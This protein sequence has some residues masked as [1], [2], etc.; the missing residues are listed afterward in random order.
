MNIIE[1]TNGKEVVLEVEGHI[2]TT[3]AQEFSGKLLSVIPLFE[4]III[5][6]VKVDYVSSA[7][8]RAFLTAQ[9]QVSNSNKELTIRNV[10]PAVMEVFEMTG[11]SQ[12]LKIEAPLKDFDIKGMPIIAAGMCGDVY[13]IDD[14]T[15]LKLYRDGFDSNMITKEKRYA[16]EA[17]ISGIPTAISL[18]M[19]KVGSRIGIIFEM[20]KAQNFANVVR[21]DLKNIQVYAKMF[22]DLAHVIHSAE[23][24]SN[25]LPDREKEQYVLFKRSTFLS[26]EEKAKVE[27]IF[28]SIPPSKTCIHG[29][30]HTGN[31]MLN[32][33]ELMFID[34]GDFA[35]GNPLQDIVHVYN[36]Y[37]RDEP[38]G[39][40]K[41][42]TKLEDNDRHE[43]YKYFMYSYF[44]I[45][46]PEELKQIEESLMKFLVIRQFFY[47]ESF[48]GTRDDNIKLV[49]NILKE[50][51]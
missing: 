14:E 36:I 12:I 17:L 51:F 8:L 49:H 11:F 15:I 10:C 48:P 37:K 46:T 50:H 40:G 20:L 25:V 5:D 26:E 32:N 6:L 22:A 4:V 24:N 30:F 7:G 47:I 31:V 18:D 19:V 16:K 21:D 3:T 41:N 29:D 1:K 34:M 39:L 35:L 27:K 23:G 2:D 28:A 42:I 44:N 13:R 9:K 45:S 43:F 33:D 38:V